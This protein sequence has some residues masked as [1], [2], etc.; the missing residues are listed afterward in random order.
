MPLPMPTVPTY[1]TTLPS[2]GKT[3]KYR[4]YLVKE[5]KILLLAQE[6]G[7]PKQI[8]EAIKK[9]VKSCIM[10]DD[11]EDIDVGKLP[12]FDVDWLFLQMRIKSSGETTEIQFI[13]KQ[14]P[15]METGCIKT[16]TINLEEVKVDKGEEIDPKIQLD[17]DL[18]V[19]MSYPTFDKLS[20]LDLNKKSETEMYFDFIRSL[21]TKVYTKEDI[22]IAGQDFTD[23]E[24]SEF[25]GA[26]NSK[27]MKKIFE[28]I[29]S[30]PTLKHQ[31]K[32]TCQEP[33]CGKEIVKDFTGAMDFFT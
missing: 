9:V 20:M 16:L 19:E 25:I 8:S 12:S 11:G 22:M 1:E 32:L 13:N 17:D 33:G 28:F 18:W 10:N 26:L 15:N 3:I 30:I 5:E 24:L 6:S 23:E 7:N 27:Q 29:N 4:P 2:N 31:V 14:C 21:I